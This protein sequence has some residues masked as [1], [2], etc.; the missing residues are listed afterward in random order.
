MISKMLDKNNYILKIVNDYL[1]F[2]IY[3]FDE[4]KKFIYKLYDKI[5]A[6]YDL[7]GH[8]VF[9]IF[10]D[11]NYGMIIEIKRDSKLVFDCISNIKIKFNINVSFLYEVDYFYLVDNEIDNQIV[12]Y[13]ND[14]YY[15]EIIN[16][17]DKCKFYNILDNSTIIYNDEINNIINKGIKLANICLL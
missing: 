9:N 3:S 4:V 15:L 17:I 12:Y 10:V 5:L 11:N 8:I 1:D 6:K 16:A 7:K 14:K 2:D 13:Y